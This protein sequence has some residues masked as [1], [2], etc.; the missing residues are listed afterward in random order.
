MSVD[1][2]SNMVDKW[3]EAIVTVKFD[4]EEGQMID[5]V[6][7]KNRFSAPL[8]KLLAYFSFPDSYVFSPEGELYYVF[9]LRSEDNEDLYC[10]TYFTQKKDST[11]PR[12]YFQKS[13]VLVSTIKMVK[14]FSVIL[15]AVNRIYFETNMDNE[16]MTNSF[17]SLNSN[18][19]PDE[20]FKTTQ[21]CMV[22]V[23]DKELKVSV[24]RVCCAMF[25]VLE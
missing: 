6:Y 19:P 13:I 23:L 20:L 2:G 14:V 25:R 8:L 10:Y 16:A 21:M 3:I 15:S 18:K 22:N 11:N 5:F 7:P 12:G 17:L 1:A 9:Q 24:N 4:L